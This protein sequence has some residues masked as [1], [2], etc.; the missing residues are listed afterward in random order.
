MFKKIIEWLKERIDTEQLLKLFSS[1]FIYGALDERLSFRDALEKALKKPIPKFVNFWF[2][3][4]GI[5]FFLFINQVITGILLAFYYK[6]SPTTAYESIKYI[7][8]E[9]P[10][11]WLIREMHAWGAN[12]MIFSVFIHIGRVFFYKAYR[13][14]RE[15]NWI[16][17]TF[18]LFMT[19]TFG[20]TG[21]LLPW[22]QLSYWA[23]TV[24]TEI[25]GG[26]PI[27][28]DF[29]LLILRGSANVSDTTLARFYAIH[30]LVLPWFI[31]FCLIAHFVMIRR[32]GISKP[33]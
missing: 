29:I 5:T 33:L 30:T 21:Y 20:F 28:G 19:L 12:L 11:G 32:Q 22:D 23:T 18:L 2:C 9:V 10:L 7:M 3:F 17:G 27:I 31:T 1:A 15:L 14:P 25:A 4:G 26:V 16:V 24:G 6:P 13:P 8:N